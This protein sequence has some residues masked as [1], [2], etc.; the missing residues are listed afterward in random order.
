MHDTGPDSMLYVLGCFTYYL[1]R[2]CMD[3]AAVK[4][5]VQTECVVVVVV[6]G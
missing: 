6:S 4:D 1:T 2:S 3:D 5:V